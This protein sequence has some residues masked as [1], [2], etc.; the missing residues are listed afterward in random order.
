V[1]NL[2]ATLTK[3]LRCLEPIQSQDEF[4]RTKHLVDVFRSPKETIGQRLQDMLIEH[5]TKS[6]NYVCKKR[7]KKNQSLIFFVFKAV[8]WWLEDM[9]LA[10][11]LP[12]PINSNPAFV[13]P[14]QQFNNTEDYLK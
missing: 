5:A 7:K 10:N 11:P 12:L 4:D 3:Y 13:L 14:Q 6:E 1:P 2:D 9:Y 8:D